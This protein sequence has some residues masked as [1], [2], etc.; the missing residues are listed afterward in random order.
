MSKVA[1]KLDAF[2]LRAGRRLG[3]KYVIDALVGSGWEGEVYRVTE[4]QTG[5]SRAVKIFYPQRNRNDEA[6]RA[7]ARKLE[8]LRECPAVVLYHH[9]ERIRIHGTP[10][11]AL[12]SEYVEGQVLGEMIGARPGRRFETYE[13]MALLYAMTCAIEQIH[14]LGEFHGDLHGGNVLVDRRGILFDLHFIDLFK[15]DV[16][17]RAARRD[18]VVDLVHLFYHATGGRRRY[19]SQPD[20]VKAI[21]KGLRRDL[22][23]ERFPTATRLRKHLER[24]GWAGATR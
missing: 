24:F 14:A 15:S 23:L 4:A 1:R 2:N 5:V 12:V 8:T 17:K 10:V 20:E 9:S 16:G 19:R 22:I 11:T 3:G 21:C 13:A 7:Y 6:V 18:D